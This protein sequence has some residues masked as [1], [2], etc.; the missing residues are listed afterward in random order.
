MLDHG[1]TLD[2]LELRKK[3]AIPGARQQTGR[4]RPFAPVIIH[5][6]QLFFSYLETNSL[7]SVFLVRFLISLVF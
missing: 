6:K 7:T 1:Q 4:E 5:K 2:H 3:R